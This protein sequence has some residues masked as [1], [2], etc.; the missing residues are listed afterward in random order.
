MTDDLAFLHTAGTHVETFQSLVERLAPSIRVSHKIA[1]DLLACAQQGGAESLPADV[2]KAMHECAAG[3]APVVVCTCSTI[4]AMAESVACEGRYHALRIDRP[5]ARL[6][7]QSGGPVVVLAA[8]A[9]TLVP[10]TALIR[11]EAD[12]AGAALALDARLVPAAWAAYQAGEYAAYHRITAG[13]IEAAA[14]SAACIVLAQ[15]SMAPAA[16]LMDHARVPVLSSPV[17][18]VRAALML[19]SQRRD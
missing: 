17:T 14:S 16:A 12:R 9:S 19:L 7:V 5:M 6:A 11:E 2:H 18:G 15:A 1:P 10:T 13:A 3:G 8:L 4:G